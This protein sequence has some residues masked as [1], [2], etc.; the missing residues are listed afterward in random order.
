MHSESGN[1][2]DKFLIGMSF[3]PTSI[4]QNE[5][6]KREMNNIK[7]DSVCMYIYIYIYIYILLSHSFVLTK[8]LLAG[9]CYQLESLIRTS[10]GVEL[11]T[12][13]YVRFHS[14]ALD[15]SAGKLGHRQIGRLVTGEQNRW[16]Q[17]GTNGRMAGWRRGVDEV[18]E[19]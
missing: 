2:H 16:Q 13:S 4:S 5:E 3:L 1:G 6:K 19:I 14:S 7:R 9:L 11:V 8:L 10:A 17:G 15:G 12:F 18:G